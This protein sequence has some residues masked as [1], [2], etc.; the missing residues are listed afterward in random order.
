MRLHKDCQGGLTMPRD[1]GI[2]QFVAERKSPKEPSTEGRT[3]GAVSQH[4]SGSYQGEDGKTLRTSPPKLSQRHPNSPKTERPQGVASRERSSRAFRHRRPHPRPDRTRPTR[5][6]RGRAPSTSS[7][8]DRGSV[9]RAGVVTADDLKKAEARYQRAARRAEEARTAR[10]RL[11][12]AA[13]AAGWTHAQIAA[14]TGLTRSRVGQIA[15]T[16]KEDTD[17]QLPR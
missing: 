17:G 14:A 16:C 3:P 5:H 15:L 7:R 12:C 4:G 9:R 2:I 11:L 1:L 8:R 6:G 10:N 13:I